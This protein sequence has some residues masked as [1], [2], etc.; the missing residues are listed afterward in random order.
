MKISVCIPMY[1]EAEIIADSVKALSDYLSRTFKN[2]EIIVSDDGSTDNSTDIVRSLGL[3]CVK[4]I[5]HK[6]NRGKGYAVRSAVL[7]ADGDII[8][9]TDADLAYG[10]EVIGQIVRVFENEPKTEIVIGSRNLGKDGYMGYTFSRRLASKLYLKILSSVGGLKLSDSQAGCKAFSKDIAHDIFKRVTVDGFAFDF[11]VIL[12]AQK[13]GYSF[14]EI[15][16][17]VLHHRDSKIRLLKDSVK[18]LS[19]LRKIKKRIRS[20]E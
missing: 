4:V 7:A 1:N 20:A 6:E 17:K 15:P 18:M 9:F 19:D 10:C 2:Y 3:P 8:I 14:T 5:G 12:L 11:E 16:I 13:F